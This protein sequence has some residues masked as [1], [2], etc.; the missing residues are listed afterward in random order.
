MDKDGPFLYNWPAGLRTVPH[1]PAP[2]RLFRF[3]DSRSHIAMSFIQDAKSKLSIF[4]ELW[5]F[6]RVRKKWWLGPIM[7]F[8]L[9]LGVLIVFTEGSA[10]APFIYALF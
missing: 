8:L 10:L 1:A 7:I 2:S 3:I 4:G 6:M 5:V 9:L